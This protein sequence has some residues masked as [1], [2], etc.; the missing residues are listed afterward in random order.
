MTGVSL[1]LRSCNYCKKQ[2]T[3]KRTTSKYCSLE[4]HWE[5]N[6]QK[7]R[8][9]KRYQRAFNLV[10]ELVDELKLEEDQNIVDLIDA[11]RSKA[12]ETST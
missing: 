11:L 12:N 6:N 5:S 9:L 8:L 1:R 3:F 10:N 4:C 7:K 2:Y